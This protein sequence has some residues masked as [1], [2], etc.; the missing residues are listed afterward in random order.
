MPGANIQIPPEL[1]WWQTLLEETAMSLAKTRAVGL[2]KKH[3]I[4]L[5]T[6]PTSYQLGFSFL[7]RNTDPYSDSGECEYVEVSLRDVFAEIGG[8]L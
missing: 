3:E 1:V 7:V 2:F 6:L 5:V 4:E 8:K